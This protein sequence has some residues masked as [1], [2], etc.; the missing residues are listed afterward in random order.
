MR[1]ILLV[2]TLLVS[3]S[4]QAI[5]VC[6]ELQ[7]SYTCGENRRVQ[8]TIIQYEDDENTMNYEMFNDHFIADGEKHE[9][10]VR[11]HAKAEYVAECDYQKLNIKYTAFHEDGRLSQTENITLERLSASKFELKSVVR[12][13]HAPYPDRVYEMSLHCELI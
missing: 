12:V 7:G 4:A 2:I 9:S 5:L 8:A 11:R 10:T 3:I 13:K 1:A 6:P